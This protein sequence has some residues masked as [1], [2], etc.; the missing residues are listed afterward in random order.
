MSGI[1]Y[2][3]FQICFPHPG[4][5]D[6]RDTT[7]RIPHAPANAATAPSRSPTATQ[8]LAA[9]ATPQP[10]TPSGNQSPRTLFA[11]KSTR[12]ILTLQQLKSGGGPKG[13]KQRRLS[14]K[15]QAAANAMASMNAVGDGSG[16]VASHSGHGYA[17]QHFLPQVCMLFL[18]YFI[19][20]MSQTSHPPPPI[21]VLTFLN[22]NVLLTLVPGPLADVGTPQQRRLAPATAA[23]T[24]PAAVAALATAARPPR[25]FVPRHRGDLFAVSC[26][27][28]G[29]HVCC[30]F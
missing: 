15:E 27:A 9:P 20:S 29:G 23:T 19:F 2:V 5:G 17:R 8:T 7:L 22:P 14:K 6:D 21:H 3:D 10:T 11:A 13:P 26:G 25:L 24:A 4:Q 18:Y 28:V 30:S 1:R 12:P 16:V